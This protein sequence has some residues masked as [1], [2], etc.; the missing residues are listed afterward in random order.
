MSD[1]N[2]PV[3]TYAA[4][5]L[6]AETP[7]ITQTELLEALHERVGTVEPETGG[8]PGAFLFSFPDLADPSREGGQ[9]VGCTIER[10]DGPLSDADIARALGQTRDWKDAGNAAHAHEARLVVSDRR[11]A[12]LGYKNRLRIFQDVVAAVSACATPTAVLWRESGKLVN[13]L[14]LTR[15]SRPGEKRDALQGA[16]NVRRLP[17]PVGGAKMALDTLGLSAL[18][19]PD[20][21]CI[22]RLEDPAKVEPFMLSI[23]RYVFDLG[24]V[25]PDGRVVKGPTGDRWILKRSRASCVPSREVLA[26]RPAN[27]VPPTGNTVVT[28]APLA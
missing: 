12:G 1:S 27:D 3:A 26:L 10:G 15:A 25:L 8:R 21:E 11:A 2:E 5:I 9:P 14:A 18:G 22:L 19:L 17:A 20:L 16:V 4:D 7:L 6:Y 23:A 13:P 28:R 24:D